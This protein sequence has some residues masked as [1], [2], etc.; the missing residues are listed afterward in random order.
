M[1]DSTDVS[2]AAVSTG[3]VGVVA[4][5]GTGGPGAV[6]R[7]TWAR[8]AAEHQKIYAQAGACRT[9]SARRRDERGGG[10]HH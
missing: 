1:Q 7:F 2:W 3:P 4:A 6:R 8:S 9:F 10:V 5:A